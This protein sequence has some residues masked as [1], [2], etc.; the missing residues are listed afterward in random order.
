[1]TL[2]FVALMAPDAEFT[3]TLVARMV[4]VVTRLHEAHSDDAHGTDADDR[5]GLDV[6]VNL[7]A[8]AGTDIFSELPKPAYR[9]WT[10]WFVATSRATR[11]SRLSLRTGIA[12]PSGLPSSTT[13]RPRRD[14]VKMAT[15]NRR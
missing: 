5:T 14:D 12:T 7:D 9:T 3:G 6:A 11:S 10:D 13:S 4:D 2:L 1:M 15:S 8:V